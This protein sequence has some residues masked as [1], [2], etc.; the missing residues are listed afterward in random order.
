MTNPI[1]SAQLKRLQTLY[2][3]FAAA[4]TDARTRGREERLLWAS[5]ILANSEQ[6]KAK[7]DPVTSFSEL[8]EP[9][10]KTLIEWLQ[11][12]TPAKS[13]TRKAK[14]G[15]PR[16]DRDQAARHAKDGRRDGA[17]FREAPQLASAYD[18]EHIE[19]YYH[20]LG[21]DRD[22]FDRWLRSPRSPL[23]R[24]SQPQIR[25]VAEANRVRW[26]L[27]RML[28][29]KGLWVEKQGL[30]VRDQGLEVRG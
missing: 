13:E 17:E 2:S 27:K 9:D 10:A 29:K 1:S 24:R 8:S 23:G 25:T 18:L 22:G 12:H 20:R 5:L 30:G 28:V 26:A 14:S 21:W 16:M 19:Q 15:R 11:K 3:R 6:R 4:S 7:S